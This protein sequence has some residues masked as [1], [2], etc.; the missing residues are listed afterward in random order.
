IRGY[1]EMIKDLYTDPNYVDKLCNFMTEH[2]LKRIERLKEI[3]V[4]I[5][6]LGED[7]GTQ[8]GMIISPKL[9]RRFFKPHFAT[10]LG[11]IK[12]AGL[13]SHLHSCG[14][15]EPIIPDLVEMGLDILNP[16]QPEAMNPAKL[17]ELYGDKLT[18]HGTISCQ[19]TLPFGS[20]ADVINEVENRIKT[21]GDKG[22]LILSPAHIVEADVPLENLL[23]L[24]QAGKKYGSYPI[25][26]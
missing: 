16:V 22:G 5:I 3:G 12:R 21:C 13:Y 8:N 26:G 14:N 2:A 1:Y 10:I 9:W 11:A 17:K 19:E 6:H 25:T 18:F 15:I 20:V 23:A 7:V 4:D 24:F